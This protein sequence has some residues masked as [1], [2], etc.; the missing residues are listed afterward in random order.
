MADYTTRYL[1]EID[2]LEKDVARKAQ[3]IARKLEAA[4][5]RSSAP[6]DKLAAAQRRLASAFDLA[7]KS[8]TSQTRR[9]G[10]YRKR[11]KEVIGHIQVLDKAVQN[12]YQNM[13]TEGDDVFDSL[14]KGA[15]QAYDEIVGHSILP[16][17][18]AAASRIYQR[19]SAQGNVV[20]KSAISDAERLLAIMRALERET[21]SLRQQPLLLTGGAG[22]GAGGTGWTNVGGAVGGAQWQKPVEDI[23]AAIKTHGPGINDWLKAFNEGL[24]KASLQWFG[25]RRLGYSLDSIGQ[26]MTRTGNAIFRAMA[27]A[28]ESYLE[29]NE[30]AT[31]A[32]I[33]M[34]MQSE[35][36]DVLEQ[37]I[38]DTSQALGL[39]APEE[40]A[41]G[42]R[43]WAAGTGEVVQTETELNNV[44]ER[45]VDLQKLAAINSEDL[46]ELT[47]I[48][49]GIMHG[50]GMTLEDVSHIIEVLNFG[51]AKTNASVVDIGQTIAYAGPLAH[52]LGIS[53]EE[54]VAVTDLLAGA[55]IK[56]TRVGRALN[57]MFIQMLK[58]TK[59]H[60]DAM[61]EALG[62]SGELNDTWQKMAWPDDKFISLANYIDFLAMT[63]ENMTE[64]ERSALLATIARAT[65]LP[66]LITL[67]EKQID[68]RKNN[69][70]AI[71]EETNAL[72]GSQSLFEQM[73]TRWEEEDANR[74][75]RMRARWDAAVKG[76]GKAV[77]EAGLPIME[78]AVDALSKLAKIVEK[79]PWLAKAALGAAA[80]N[81]VVGNL[82]R[83]VAQLALSIANFAIMKTAVAA[84]GAAG[85][86]G[87]AGAV[88]GGTGVAV[89]GAAAAAG[90][91]AAV[92]GLTIAGVAGAAFI[93]VRELL[94]N[95]TLGSR[96]LLEE[97]QEVQNRFNELF[98]PGIGRQVYTAR[99][100]KSLELL[101][102]VLGK[103]AMSIM[104]WDKEGRADLD[105]LVNE[106]AKLVETEKEIF[107]ARRMGGVEEG[108]IQAERVTKVGA[109]ELHPP[110]EVSPV[111]A[112]QK[113]I[114]DELVAL[115]EEYEETI[116]QLRLKSDE[117]FAAAHTA[118]LDW[119]SAALETHLQKEASL[120]KNYAD[121]KIKRLAAYN[122]SEQQ[123]KED[124][125]VK[126]AQRL[127]DFRHQ[128]QQ[129]EKDYLRQLEK[130]AV[131]HAERLA[132]LATKAQ[133]ADEK[134]ADAY[135]RKMQQLEEDYQQELL[136]MAEDYQKAVQE[137]AEEHA[138]R[139]SDLA[140]Q[141]RQD[142]LDDAKQ[143]AERLVE[144]ETSYYEAVE[145]AAEQH[146]ERM[147]DRAKG[148]QDALEDDAKRH[149]ERLADI[150]T[151]YHEAVEEDAANHAE[152]L[153]D[154]RKNYEEG[155]LDDAE[156]H[157]KRLADLEESLQETL[158][159]DA[160]QHAERLASLKD[161]YQKRE[162]RAA[163][164]HLR[165]MERMEQD[166][167]DRM[168]DLISTRDAR[169]LL[170][171]MRDYT[172]KRDETEEDYETDKERREKDYEDRVNEE[173]E[174]Y[175]KDKER[176]QRDY[177]DRRQ[178]EIERYEEQKKKRRED[179][180]ERVNE[181]N[182]RAEK[183]AAKRRKD[184]EKQ[185]REE[186]ERFE[187]QKKKRQ[188]DYEERVREEEE[189]SA[190]EAQK[191]Q[192][193]YEKQVAEEE[194][195]AEEEKIARE[196]AYQEQLAEEKAHYAEQLAEEEAY[197]LERR[198]KRQKE[199][200]AQQQEATENYVL[201]RSARREA[202]A[203]QIA[204]ENEQYALQ[205]ERRQQEYALERQDAAENYRLA[206]NRRA[207][208]FKRARQQAADAFTRKEEDAAAQYEAAMKAE[209]TRYKI[210]YDKRKEQYEE[211][212]ALLTD[213]LEEEEQ[214]AREAHLAKLRKLAG[215]WDELE[216]SYQAH[217]DRLLRD[218]K[219]FLRDYQEIWD[220][221]QD[222]A[223]TLPDS[224]DR[225]RLG[226]DEPG[227]RHTGGYALFGKY[228]LGEA[229]KEYVLNADTVRSLESRF[230]VLNQAMFKGEV[231]L[232]DPRW[233]IEPPN[234]PRYRIPT[235]PRLGI[236]PLLLMGSRTF[237][238]N[239]NSSV[240]MR[241]TQQN[242]WHLPVGTSQE[243]LEQVRE[244]AYAASYEAITAASR[245]ALT[246]LPR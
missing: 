219:D 195:R 143:H 101:E 109:A 231:F 185:I 197:Y 133:E 59:D 25:L 60:N 246:K 80:L 214:A 91:A 46:G 147:A 215:F 224:P 164:D 157:A 76:V 15:R 3:D 128:E 193:D 51:A 178:E 29:F 191:R 228:W 104:Y 187:A 98:R 79:Y 120:E 181:E 183:I 114:N 28:G 217:Y 10:N 73:W 107:A 21:A 42:L 225:P 90:S 116:L 212:L 24:N 86:A 39:F 93:V 103:Q 77:V 78:D 122:L 199:Y 12:V 210:S 84:A 204:D 20:F 163:E 245:E 121:G 49:G 111:S 236:E 182:E 220:E 31:R 41:E 172:R 223:D 192:E 65:E 35:M 201:A 148:L 4:L 233:V 230:G 33:A 190:K 239:S 87:T 113:K 126:E 188:E 135:H 27:Q 58:P 119:Q 184:Y 241:M 165:R 17:M 5:A 139:L 186:N 131:Q 74:A 50:F 106:V 2:I 8:I 177:E 118:W 167:L 221:L 43:L 96:R 160:E 229:G 36:Q 130:D 179:Y 203:K 207:E 222:L 30:A 134:A 209:D 243:T 174:R 240:N 144:I 150:E 53:F 6:D 67:I 54:L 18:E 99:T 216:G 13:S 110:G 94:Q 141:N 23:S 238:G 44:L 149:A 176:R 234:D 136:Q 142:I 213:E 52:Q 40:I 235:D 88:A 95:P 237:G 64:M 81:L 71:Q 123:A 57:Q 161:D 11:V 155:I 208:N 125:A 56:G 154:L 158:E 140:E 152:R 168:D 48:T 175:A 153:A 55:N 189:R 117:K 169:G 75:K 226:G 242:V 89:G 194:E 72:T 211:Q 196:E 16:D 244:I 66:V 159:K 47:K 171:E 45:V 206:A 162:A 232:R 124:F 61:N 9:L 170:R 227:W 127:E 26:S 115:Q 32:A 108:W 173:N 83:V 132:N 70:D 62:L 85:A 129:A 97:S 137:A 37:K 218:V 146:A 34:E 100:E 7:N 145:D 180:E 112:E 166:H 105:K 63:T 1:F 151:S 22:A 200:T 38:L 202:Y 138:E 92:T 19:I 82:A 69:I 198:E 102:K 205:K 156:K 14:T 68:A